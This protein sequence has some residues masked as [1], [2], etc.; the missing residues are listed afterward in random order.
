M[1]VA[2]H[3]ELFEYIFVYFKTVVNPQLTNTHTT[4]AKLLEVEVHYAVK[5][6]RRSHSDV[7]LLQG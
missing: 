7:L 6:Y 1:C 5:I 4:R 2:G 3:D